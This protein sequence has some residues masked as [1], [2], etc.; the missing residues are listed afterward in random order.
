VILYLGTSSLVKMYVD[1]PRSGLL[2][3]WVNDAEVIAT[4]RL[5]YT[6]FVSSLD[7]RYVQGDLTKKDYDS[8]VKTFADDWRHFAV[9]DF[10]EIEAGNL[11]MKHGLRRFDALHL[12]AVKLLQGTGNGLSPVF[13]SADPN[14]IRAASAEGF[15]VLELCE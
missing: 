14:L 7:I 8:I 9:L 6:E 1:E 13:S 5:A 15:R 3:E 11:A 10:D 12:S 2:R 4:C